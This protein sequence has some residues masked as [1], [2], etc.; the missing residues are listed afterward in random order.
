MAIKEAAESE[1]FYFTGTAIMLSAVSGISSSIASALTISVI[2]KSKDFKT[3][4]RIMLF[5]ACCD[6]VT[7]SLMGLSTTLMPSDVIYPFSGPAFI[8]NTI[9]CEAQGFLIITGLAFASWSNMYLNVY[10]L[11]TIRYSFGEEIFRKFD[12]IFLGILVCFALPLPIYFWRQN[13]INPTPL[14]TY[15]TTGPYPYEC[16]TNLNV[17]C[18]RGKS[19]S[20]NVQYVLTAYAFL[21]WGLQFTVLVI[22]MTLIIQTFSDADRA[23]NRHQIQRI[24]HSRADEESLGI[25]ESARSMTRTVMVQAFMYVLAYLI[26]I[27]IELIALFETPDWHSP[28]YAALKEFLFPLQGFFNAFIFIYHKAL[29]VSRARPELSK[30]ACLKCVLFR[31]A[32]VPQFYISGMFLVKNKRASDNLE[33]GQERSLVSNEVFDEEF[34]KLSNSFSSRSSEPSDCLKW[35]D[36]EHDYYPSTPSNDNQSLALS[37]LGVKVPDDEN[38]RKNIQ[39]VKTYYY[40]EVR[41]IVSGARA[42]FTQQVEEADED[43]S[44]SG[45]GLISYQHKRVH[46]MET[47]EEENSEIT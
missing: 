23:L 6:F 30:W 14:E 20:G 2:V 3:Y 34:N 1:K 41:N 26:V 18:I 33:R 46:Q 29:D 24:G 21:G 11:C 31:P 12:F 22:T 4:H 44:T 47:I 43:D 25:L 28:R 15:C 36:D 16:F 39:S 35:N 42:P 5:M 32:T 37:A 13:F 8:G 10:Y 9:S 45:W 27:P 7:G 19:F 40:H 17:P 38:M